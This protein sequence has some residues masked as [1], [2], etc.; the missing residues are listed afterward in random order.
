MMRLADML[1]RLEHLRRDQR[2]VE[3]PTNVEIVINMPSGAGKSDA[4][5]AQRVRVNQRRK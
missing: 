2:N 3:A 1:R 5:A 4:K